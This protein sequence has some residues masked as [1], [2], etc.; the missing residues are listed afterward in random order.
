MEL[1]E[2]LTTGRGL[3]HK[4]GDVDGTEQ[5]PDDGHISVATDRLVAAAT[6]FSTVH[7]FG[8]VRGRRVVA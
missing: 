7:F 4:A 3:M 5:F 6:P 8:K 2:V 1:V